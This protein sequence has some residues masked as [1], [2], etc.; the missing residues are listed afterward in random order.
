MTGPADPTLDRLLRQEAWVTAKM[1]EFLRSLPE[2]TLKATAP[3]TDWD[4]ATTLVHIVDANA[5]YSERMEGRP[6]PADFPK[7]ATHADL[8]TLER[9]ALA[10]LARIRALAADPAPEVVE[11]G[12]EETWRYPRSL[13]LAQALYHSIEHR[14]QLYGI[15]AANGVEGQTLDD[16]DH[17]S[18]GDSEGEISK[19]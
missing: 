3:S 11:A 10:D 13:L 16:L 2:A 8:D 18:F 15:L 6:D 5:A 19:S 9:R 1:F 7:P 4:V 12:E 14:A 17:W